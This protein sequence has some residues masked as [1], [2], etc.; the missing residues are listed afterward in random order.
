MENRGIF[1]NLYEVI[2]KG[3]ASDRICI[4][5]EM[6][7]Y[8]WMFPEPFRRPQTTARWQRASERTPDISEPISML[9]LGGERGGWEV[10]TGGI[11]CVTRGWERNL[12]SEVLQVRFPALCP[13]SC[14]RQIASSGLWL[15]FSLVLVNKFV[16]KFS[17]EPVFNTASPWSSSQP[18]ER[19]LGSDAWSTS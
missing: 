10:G 8:Y 4:R 12:C 13:L 15:F 1:Q 17:L 7:D 18:A 9:W 14:V 19:H 6:K 2:T 11:K 5:E 3:R 16:W